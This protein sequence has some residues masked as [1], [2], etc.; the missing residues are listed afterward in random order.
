MFAYL[1]YLSLRGF[2]FF[3]N[4]LPE[5]PS[6]WLGR[7]LGRTAFSLFRDRRGIALR[8]LRAAFGYEKSEEEIQQI[9]QQTFV[10]LGMT[11]VEF[12]RIPKMDAEDV[13]QKITVEGLENAEKVLDN[14]KKGA[15]LVLSHFGN[16]ELMGVIPRIINHP[17]SV[18]AKPVKDSRI[19]RWVTHIREGA[20]LTVIQAEKAGRRIIGALRENG[21][22]GILIDQRA[23]RSECI[24]VD[25]F[26][27]KAPTTPA[28]AV[29]AA[30]T[31]VPVIPVFMV[32]IGNRRH[33][34]VIKDPLRLVKTG[35]P[36]KDAETNTE[37]MNRSLESMIRQYP[38]HWFWVHRRWERK[39]RTR[40]RLA[41][42]TRRRDFH[43]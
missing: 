1:Q 33:R 12:F 21:I 43:E 16:W 40:H 34:L 3:V 14:E 11:A 13:K 41:K 24:W 32:R 29:L 9:A 37:L 28:V 39:K 20:G 22:V 38:D 42:E 19:D 7:Q 4:L 26:G 25:F 31:G 30:R 18:I 17:I 6:L 27:K 23:K 15:L 2:S 36:K 5:G 8:N 35:D 10:N